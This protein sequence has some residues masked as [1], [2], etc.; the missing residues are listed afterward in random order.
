MYTDGQL[1]HAGAKTKQ[2]QNNTK[3]TCLHDRDQIYCNDS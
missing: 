3:Q 1:V 2:K